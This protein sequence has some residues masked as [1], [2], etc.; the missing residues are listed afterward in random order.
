M[1]DSLADSGKLRVQAWSKAIERHLSALKL[2]P[3]WEPYSTIYVGGG[4]P[5]ALP[6]AELEHLLALLADAFSGNVTGKAPGCRAGEKPG[7]DTEWTIE[8]N[9]DDL[10]DAM[11]AG[12]AAF[13]VSRL[14]VGIQSLEDAVRQVVGRRGSAAEILAALGNLAKRWNRDWSAD[15]MYGMPGQTPAGLAQDLRR[16][17]DL[18]AAHVSLYQLTLEEGTVL[19]AE[20]KRG[21]LMLP[22]QDLSADQY[23]AA[24]S[25]LSAAGYL[26]YEVSNWALPGKEC[27]HNLQYWRMDDWDAIGPSGVSN[28]RYGASFSRGQNTFD[29]AVYEEDPLG[30]VT[31]STVN[32][33]DAMFESLMMALRT[34]EGFSLHRF[35]DIFGRDPVLVFGNLSEAF[36]TLIRQISGFWR[37]SD[38]GMDM[39]N[40]VLVAALETAGELK[41][42]E[43]GGLP[44]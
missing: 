36:P 20:L 35:H 23:M 10:S 2:T 30:S 19:A 40:R 5:S 17:I 24:A 15:F 25:V 21:S 44:L 13:G 1:G 3:G 34:N 41:K 38:E 32:G 6:P 27:Q 26:R 11:L 39:L 28:H 12:L 33:V 31:C 37:P 43:T 9:P 16:I 29:D 8:C 14:S 22:D 42:P 4:T 7:N 18:G